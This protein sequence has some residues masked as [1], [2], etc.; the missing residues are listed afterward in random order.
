[1]K[2]CRKHSGGE[3]AGGVRVV[4]KRE[5]KSRNEASIPIKGETLRSPFCCIWMGYK[6][7]PCSLLA[8]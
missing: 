6:W 5:Q 3:T 7:F 8:L 2:G 1:M 4:C